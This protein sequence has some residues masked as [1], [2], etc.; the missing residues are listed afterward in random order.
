MKKVEF[1]I[2]GAQKS[3]TSSLAAVLDNHPLLSC[4]VPK[5][6]HFFSKEK[7]WKSKLESYHSLFKE[8]DAIWFEASTSYS[9]YPEFNKNIAKDIQ[10][11]NPEMKFIYIIRNPYDRIISA[12]RHVYARGYEKR[13]FKKAIRSS[14]NLYNVTSYYTQAKNYI[15]VFGKDKLLILNFDD[16]NNNRIETL[17]QISKYLNIS[18]ADFPEN[19]SEVK[20][21]TKE[22]KR[23]D[24]RIDQLSSLQT[25]IKYRFP[26][27]W[28][29]YVQKF[30][31]HDLKQKIEL[32]EDD[33]SF[34]KSKLKEDMLSL[35]Q[36]D[37]KKPQ[38]LNDFITD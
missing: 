5:E 29:W 38:W 37:F 31:T 17:Q 21:N 25:K 14:V 35:N 13:N 24:Y 23:L 30:Y 26:R 28:K 4:S 36:L 10:S 22:S 6:P 33:K 3:A 1:I 27:F 8:K 20:I 12:Y 9:F 15:D 2:I 34:I 11:Y 32:N 18:F 19:V 7:D 16:F